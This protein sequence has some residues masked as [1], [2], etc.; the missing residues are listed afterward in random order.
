MTVSLIRGL[1]GVARPRR[2]AREWS[3]QTTG[4][5]SCHG[6]LGAEEAAADVLELVGCAGG[7][8][9]VRRVALAAHQVAADQEL[10][11][12]LGALLRAADEGYLVADDVGD[13]AG[14][15]RVV[16]AAEDQ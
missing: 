8:E 7:Q 10:V 3:C 4:E 14:E 11:D 1:R 15:Q 13:H 2:P 5:L 12:V 9:G 6:E 16:G